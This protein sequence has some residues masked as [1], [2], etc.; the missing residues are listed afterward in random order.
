[1]KRGIAGLLVAMLVGMLGCGGEPASAKEAP[2]VVARDAAAATDAGAARDAASVDAGAA[3]AEAAAAAACPPCPACAADASTPH[4]VLT[5]TKATFA[6]LPGWADDK[7]AEAVVSFLRSCEAIGKLPDAAPVGADGHGGIAKQWRSACAKAAKLPAG[8]HA[9]ARR[10]FEAEFTPFAAAGAKGPDGLFTGYMVQSLRASR[11]RGGK[12]QYPLYARPKD[13]VVVDLSLYIKDARGRRIWGRLDAKGEL[14][15]Y[16]ARK[17]IRQGALDGR[18]LEIMYADDPVD[19]LFA[20]IEGSAKVQLDDGTSTWLEFAG[21]N[22]LAFRGAG[23]VLKAMGAFQPPATGTMQD[24]RAWFAANPT[25][26][27]EIVDQSPSFVFFRES[28]RPGAVGTQMVV[29]TDR[30]SMAIDRAF[31]AFGTPLWLDTYAPVPG[32]AGA[33]VWRRLLIA[34]DTGGAILGAVRGDIYF[35]DDEAAADVA[36]RM[37]TKG[38]YWLLLPNGVTK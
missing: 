6:D 18:G 15:P 23:G 28:K 11:K 3:G 2:S 33:T 8:D 29:L 32:K 4:D 31:I 22:G 37:G 12:Y 20:H 21:K 9:A 10:M 7:H 36:G 16:F 19:V 26:F 38:R 35:G 1:M 14:V 13:L 24:I 17:E 27:D 5:L 30:R 25:R 34:Q